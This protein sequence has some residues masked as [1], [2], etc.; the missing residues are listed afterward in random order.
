[1]AYQ[2]GQAKKHETPVPILGRTSSGETVIGQT[3]PAA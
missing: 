3:V 1:M 2:V